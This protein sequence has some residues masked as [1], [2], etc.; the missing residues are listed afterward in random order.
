LASPYFLIKQ[1]IKIFSWNA[2][3]SAQ[4]YLIRRGQSFDYGAL[5]SIREAACWRSNRHYFINRDITMYVLLLQKSLLRTVENFLDDHNIA[6]D[7]FKEQA[8]II[9]DASNK[10]YSVHIG[11]VSNSTFAV[12]DK[13]KA[14]GEGKKESAD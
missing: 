8:K 5:R 2:R 3:E 4:G 7:E 12:G 13:A 11:N 9:I 10:N 1:G 6:T 14:S